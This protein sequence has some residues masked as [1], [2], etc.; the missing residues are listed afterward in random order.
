MKWSI[1]NPEEGQKRTRRK[2]AWEPTTVIDNGVSVRVW[3]EWYQVTE[4]FVKFKKEIVEEW[5]ILERRVIK[6]G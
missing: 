3:L 5:V 4:E 1:P 6:K 2:F